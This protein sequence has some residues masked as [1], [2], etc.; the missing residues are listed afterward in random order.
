MG[1][2]LSIALLLAACG[3]SGDATKP[4]EG[5]AGSAPAASDFDKRCTQL[6]KVCGDK[7]KHIAKIHDGCVAAAAKCPDTAMAL[8]DCF[9]QELCLKADK[10]W[11][12]EDLGVLAER[13]KNCADQRKASA[14]CVAK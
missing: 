7:D 12:F 8:F 11:T 6:A 9:E 5:S 2:A 13:K 10:V 3:K 1:R 14:A 4:P